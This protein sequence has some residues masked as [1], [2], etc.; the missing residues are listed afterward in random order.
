M[1]GLEVLR[2]GYD[3]V[4][5]L[6]SGRYALMLLL[7]FGAWI[8]ESIV[9]FGVAKLYA[10]PFTIET[11]SDYISSILSANH[12]TLMQIYTFLS[13]VV[14]AVLTIAALIVSMGKHER[15]SNKKVMENKS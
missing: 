1:K 15:K 14:I 2:T 11:F 13:I 10:L 6:V 3:Y 5:H 8:M 7:S 9:L 4:K 12:N